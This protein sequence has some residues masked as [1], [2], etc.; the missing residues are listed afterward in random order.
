[1]I[2]QEG[3]KEKPYDQ[4]TSKPITKI[5]N[6]A[7]PIYIYDSKGN[8]LAFHPNFA[9]AYNCH[10]YVW[11]KSGGDPTISFHGN[12]IQNSTNIRFNEKRL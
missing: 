10:A 8:I 12:L 7:T 5:S 3:E 11:H 4:A 1:M 9:Q 6:T 2:D